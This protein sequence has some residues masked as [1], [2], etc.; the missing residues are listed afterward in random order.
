M[1]VDSGALGAAGEM[2]RHIGVKMKTQDAVK[3]LIFRRCMDCWAQQESNNPF[4]PSSN[5]TFIQSCGVL[6][7]PLWKHRLSA[8]WLQEEKP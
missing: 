6:A 8:A 2:L 7:C 4:S 5:L 3:D 1:G